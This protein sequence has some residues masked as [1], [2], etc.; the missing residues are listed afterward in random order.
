MTERYLT[1]RPGKNGTTRFF[2][3]PPAALAEHGFKLTRLGNDAA[4]ASRQAELLNAGL[5]AFRA[6]QPTQQKTITTLAQLIADYKKT[7]DWKHQLTTSTRKSYSYAMRLLLAQMPDQPVRTITPALLERFYATLRRTPAAQMQAAR[8]VRI[9]MEHAIRRGI[10]TLNPAL[11]PRLSYTPTRAMLW[12]PEYI[13]AFVQAADTLQL[14][15]MGTA[16][17]LNEWTGQ[18]PSDIMALRM[19]AFQQGRLRLT[20][21]KTGATVE[22]PV[23]MVPHIAARLAEQ[24]KRNLE[25]NP[26]SI[27]LLPGMRGLGMN[28]AQFRSVFNLIRKAAKLPATLT[29]RT[30]R[31]T[32]V[33]RMGEAGVSVQQIAAVTGHKLKTCVNILETYNIATSKMAEEAFRMRMAAERMAV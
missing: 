25:R 4:E 5:D 6:G 2:W 27:F 20:Q 18:R 12:K 11:K 28:E 14:F 13:T 22:L 15:D 30:L 10:L 1:A 23:D 17:L 8:V 19:D 3:Q 9:L 21:K 33:T 16:V 31:H 7:L 29:F 32:A 26:A 24:V